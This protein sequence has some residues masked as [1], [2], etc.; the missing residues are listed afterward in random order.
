MSLTLHP[1]DVYSGDGVPARCTNALLGREAQAKST[2][3]HE[4]MCP[5][6]LFASAVCI[7]I[8]TVLTKIF[9][10]RQ[11]YWGFF[12]SG[13]EKGLAEKGHVE[14]RQ[15]SSKVSRQIWTF[16][17]TYRAG[18]KTSKIVKECQN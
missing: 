10:E 9:A 14:K 3:H 13:P 12:F 11:K 16:F 2:Y 15:D 18:P 7:T 6:G 8:L 4:L 17:H 5:Q 1:V